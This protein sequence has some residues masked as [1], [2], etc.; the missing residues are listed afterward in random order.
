MLQY[1]R[2]LQAVG[3]NAIERRVAFPNC[4]PH[5]LVSWLPA[6]HTILV[7]WYAR[8]PKNASRCNAR[9]RRRVDAGE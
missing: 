6:S 9:R 4:I 5:A 7:Q 1:I 8:V 2:L 3:G